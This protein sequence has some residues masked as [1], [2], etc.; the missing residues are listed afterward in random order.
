[1]KIRYLYKFKIRNAPVTR[2]EAALSKGYYSV[3]I[4]T[5]FKINLYKLC[6]ILIT[7]DECIVYVRLKI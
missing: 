5:P 1:M 3:I 7:S 6:L 4:T 2:K